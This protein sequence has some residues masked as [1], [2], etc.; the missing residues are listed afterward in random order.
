MIHTKVVQE[1]KYL[2]GSLYES[3]FGCLHVFVVSWVCINCII[4]GL[5]LCL[6]HETQNTQWKLGMTVSSTAFA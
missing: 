2:T 6:M 4:S 5:Y 1:R 3:V